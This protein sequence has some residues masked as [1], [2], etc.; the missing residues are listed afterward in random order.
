[1]SNLNNNKK[2][3]ILGDVYFSD[4]DQ[5][6]FFDKV[7]NELKDY[8][9]LANLEGSIKFNELPERNKAI[10]LSVPKFK[11]NEIPKNLLFSL[12]NN[13]IT[14]YGY[15]N[16]RCNVNYLDNFAVFS[17]HNNI[18][19]YIG[20]EKF[21]FLADK[22]EQ[23][24]LKSTKFLSFSNKQVNKIS[25]EIKS[26][27]IIIHGGIEHRKY[28]TPYQRNLARKI[29]DLGAKM[30]VF[31]HS[32]KVGY[33]EHWNKKLI[34]YGLGNAFFSNT[35][36]VHKLSDS[37]SEGI[38]LGKKTTIFNLNQ[39][40][41]VNINKPNFSREIDNLK[42]GEYVKF[43]KDR[44]KLDSSFRPRQLKRSDFYIF[45]QFYIW[46]SIANT[47]VRFKISTKIKT[48]LNYLFYRNNKK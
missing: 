30:V 9:V 2:I 18:V 23:C 19:N 35:F 46:S 3:L 32:H 24:Q 44:Y 22:K 45:I 21:I 7:K 1:M 25:D 31:H 38:C 48:I 14:D 11:K 39:L 42:F 10:H 15:K 34:H 6:I 17:T 47:L 12:V 33:H 26:S 8:Y 5:Y 27:V 37:I 41:L 28:P 4:S 13:H 20:N 29:I 16:F 43:Y 40:K 36:N